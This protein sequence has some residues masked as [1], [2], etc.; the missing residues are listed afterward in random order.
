MSV[1]KFLPSDFS[2]CSRI[3]EIERVGSL[4]SE[5]SLSHLEKNS[6]KQLVT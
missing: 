2:E 1:S 3:N 5:I 6:T 4:S